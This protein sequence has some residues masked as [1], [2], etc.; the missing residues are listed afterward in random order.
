MSEFFFIKMQ[1]KDS[2]VFSGVHDPV[3][4]WSGSSDLLSRIRELD[5]EPDPDPTSYPTF[6]LNTTPVENLPQVSFF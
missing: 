6:V 2:S 3:D 1:D 5:P 4:V